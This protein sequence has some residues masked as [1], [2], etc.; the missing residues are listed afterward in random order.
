MILGQTTFFT[1]KL[2]SCAVQFSSVTHLCLTL[3]NHMGCSTPGFPVH[4][5]LPELSQFLV[6]AATAAKLLQSCPTLRPHRRQPTR[7]PRPWDSPGKNTGV[8]CHFLLQCMK[9]KSQSKVAPSCRLYLL[10]GREREHPSFSLDDTPHKHRTSKG[11]LSVPV[12]SFFWYFHDWLV[13]PLWDSS[14]SQKCTLFRGL[15]FSSAGSLQALE[16]ATPAR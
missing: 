3:C 14:S 2:V 8:G 6:A 10:E 11:A 1:C 16:V 9:V 5:Q 12:S 4:H 15:R 7:H 13:L